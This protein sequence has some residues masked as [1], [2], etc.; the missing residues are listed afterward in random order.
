MNEL[1]SNMGRFSSPEP[2]AQGELLW[3]KDICKSI[4]QT[5]VLPTIALNMLNFD[6]HGNQKE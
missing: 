4:P 1:E 3:S 2:M 5:V 6:C